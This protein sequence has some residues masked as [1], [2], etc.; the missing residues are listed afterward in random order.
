MCLSWSSSVPKRLFL[1]LSY[2]TTIH[3]IGWCYLFLVCSI[4]WG[5]QHR[6]WTLQEINLE[7]LWVVIHVLPII[8]PPDTPT[9]DPPTTWPLQTYHR[10]HPPSI[11]HVPSPVPKTIADSPPTPPTSLDLA[12]QPEFDLPIA[13]RK[14]NRTTLN[15]YLH[16]IVFP[17]CIILVFLLCL[18]FLLL[19]LQVKHFRT[20]VEANNHWRDVCSS[21]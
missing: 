21:K 20:W 11:V 10:R 16:Y 17:L 15:P 3:H 1:L 2:A 12:L 5:N 14:D 13:L 6:S 7:P 18:L 9:I 4:F 19:N 8:A